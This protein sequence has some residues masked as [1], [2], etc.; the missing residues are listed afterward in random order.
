MGSGFDIQ[1]AGLKEFN[2]K[3]TKNWLTKQISHTFNHLWQKVIWQFYDDLV[4][5]QTSDIFTAIK[6]SFSREQYNMEVKRMIFN[7]GYIP[8]GA[9]T[10]S[11]F[12][13][14]CLKD[15]WK[16]YMSPKLVG[17]STEE[18]HQIFLDHAR[19]AQRRM[20]QRAPNTYVLSPDLNPNNVLITPERL[21]HAMG[22]FMLHPI[23]SEYLRLLGNDAT[24]MG[25]HWDTHMQLV[26]LDLL[27]HSQNLGLGKIGADGKA[28]GFYMGMGKPE[29]RM[30]VDE[31]FQAILNG[32]LAN[33]ESLHDATRYNAEKY[34]TDLRGILTKVDAATSTEQL[35]AASHD[36]REFLRKDTSNMFLRMISFDQLPKDGSELE[37]EFV[38]DKATGRPKIDPATGEKI[39]N[40][41]ADGRSKKG[42]IKE[43]VGKKFGVKGYGTKTEWQ[44][45]IAEYAKSAQIDGHDV[46]NLSV[47]LDTIESFRV[48]VAYEKEVGRHIV[49][50]F[51][52]VGRMNQFQDIINIYG[53]AKGEYTKKDVGI[54]LR[55]NTQLYGLSANPLSHDEAPVKGYGIAMER[56]PSGAL[57]PK[58]EPVHDASGAVIGK[59]LV[60]E[61]G[62]VGTERAKDPNAVRYVGERIKSI[63]NLEMPEEGYSTIGTG[64]KIAGRSF[65]QSG[66]FGSTK[67]HDPNPTLEGALKMP[68]PRKK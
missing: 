68:A 5:D 31:I 51:E 20:Y 30:G 33:G 35:A 44:L 7:D 18:Q 14:N 64:L 56:D 40:L 32:R 10:D 49:D 26:G 52:N 53:Q 42:L 6:N 41:T 48:D 50:P 36:L 63:E 38:I 8:E 12:I 17:K 13:T 57:V 16:K 9:Y 67:M 61:K 15:Y 43:D 1:E 27:K 34:M 59:R 28:E 60:T 65:K 29:Q 11:K 62:K 4:K 54:A 22:A 47:V 55:Q 24:R 19:D 2:K 37:P 46:R 45:M 3:M 21:D 58:T 39:K 25:M 66:V 23:R